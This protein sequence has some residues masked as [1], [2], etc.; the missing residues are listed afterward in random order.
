MKG[1]ES[2]SSGFKSGIHR[3]FDSSV[4][5]LSRSDRQV[6]V[7]VEASVILHTEYVW[8]GKVLSDKPTAQPSI[9]LGFGNSGL[10]FNVFG[11]AAVQDRDTVGVEATDEVNLTLSYDRNIGGP[12]RALGISIGYTQY[13]YPRLSG[14]NHSEEVFVGIGLGSPLQPAVTV[15]YDFGLRNS[16]YAT[17]GFNPEFTLDGE[18]AQLVSVRASVGF[19]NERGSFAFNDVTV[20]VSASVRKGALTVGPVAQFVVADTALNIDKDKLWGGLELRLS[21]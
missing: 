8:R 6:N 3:V 19:S 4:D 7:S 18:G 11:S 14:A 21:Y 13:V 16:I 20:S 2:P 1:K 10:A 12:G 15:F 5:Y 9:T 17:F